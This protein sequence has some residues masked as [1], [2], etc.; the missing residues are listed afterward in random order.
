MGRTYPPSD[1]VVFFDVGGTLLEVSPSVG[2]VYAAACSRMGTQVEPDSVQRAFD[3]AWVTLSE[4]VPRG[5]DR[6]RAFPGGETAWWE[7][8][9]SFA[10]DQCG[11]PLE[12]RP[13]VT[14]LRAVFAGAGAWRVFPETRDALRELQN[15][16]YRL[17]VL[18][19]WD[20]RLP[21]L[22]TTLELDGFFETIV[23]S[24]S[25]GYE[26]PHPAIFTAALE[27]VGARPELTVHIGDRLEEDYAGAR[28]AGMAALLVSRQSADAAPGD[29]SGRVAADNLVRDL[30][31]AVKWIVG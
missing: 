2:H 4:Q 10:F 3:K 17:G 22:L 31:E 11:V 7:K 24:A 26:K 16:G 23:H 1:T 19:N 5:A 12:G 21:A 9:S 18:S 8:V 14:E 6:Y 13:P 30:H 28:A 27:A 29:L 15:R 25:T 20:S